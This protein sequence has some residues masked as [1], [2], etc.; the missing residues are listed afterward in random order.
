MGLRRRRSPRSGRSLRSAIRGWGCTGSIYCC[1]GTI[2]GYFEVYQF[3]N[4]FSK[5]NSPIAHAIGFWDYQ[6]F[7]ALA[8][9]YEPLG[10]GTTGDKETKMREVAAFLG[11]VGIHTSCKAQRSFLDVNNSILPLVSANFLFICILDLTI[12][13]KHASYVCYRHGYFRWIWC[14]N[15]HELRPSQ[16]YCSPNF[17]Y[18]CAPAGSFILWT[19]CSTYLLEL[20]LW[21]YGGALGRIL[22]SFASTSIL[23]C[24]CS[25]CSLYFH[26][27]VC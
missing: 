2:T 5:R 10:F 11:H 9:V 15:N 16:D 24:N 13:S 12:A 19:R 22:Q 20:Q 8:A 6:S 17:L 23:I 26:V 27:N 1:N 4:L 7:I 25:S 3:E 14:C 18:P 21:T